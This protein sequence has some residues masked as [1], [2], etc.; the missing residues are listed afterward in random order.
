MAFFDRGFPPAFGR[1]DGVPSEVSDA[2]GAE[3]LSDWAR[4]E[5]DGEPR[6]PPDPPPLET[7]ES[8]LAGGHLGA[9]EAQTVDE[10]AETEGAPDPIN[11]DDADDEPEAEGVEFEPDWFALEVEDFD[12][13][14]DADA[15]PDPL[16]EEP[17]FDADDHA[18]FAETSDL[19]L[20]GIEVGDSASFGWTGTL[21][22]DEAQEDA[23]ED[24]GGVL[25][26]RAA[27]LVVLRRAYGL[28]RREADHRRLLAVLAE[29][30]WASS[31]GAIQRLMEAGATIEDVEECARVKCL[32]RDSPELWLE[33]CFDRGAGAWSPVAHPR[34]RHAMTWVLAAQL[35]DA[36]G[37]GEIE[38][39]IADGWL[40]DWLDLS[41][42]PWA[43]CRERDAAFFS[44]AAHLTTIRTRLSPRCPDAWLH[45]GH[46][47]RGH[48]HRE[49]AVEAEGRRR[50]RM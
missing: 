39:S 49:L 14:D 2:P 10:E 20:V 37:A 13:A 48:I 41:G 43:A 5:A 45:E 24:D 3:P 35:V 31:F 16:D 6:S 40:T 19:D 46:E 12:A 36:F 34:Q 29:F 28:A 4:G 30:P 1:G 9:C 42:D 11:F 17:E 22:W 26:R 47:E 38:C 33:R 8:N 15:L 21:E 44:F 50:A 27:S 32:W 18:W 23:A 25:A 7:D